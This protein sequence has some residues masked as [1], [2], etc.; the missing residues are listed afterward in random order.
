[1]GNNSI[2]RFRLSPSC[3]RS[4]KEDH[5][6]WHLDDFRTDTARNDLFCSAYVHHGPSTR[7]ERYNAVGRN[8]PDGVIFRNHVIQNYQEL[9]IKEKNGRTKT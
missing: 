1:M 4:A 7:Q 8:V 9:H 3:R 6:Y 5:S 2:G